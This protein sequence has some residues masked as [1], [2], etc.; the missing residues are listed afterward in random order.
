MTL[1]LSEL[2]VR[3][4]WL[5]LLL[6]ILLAMYAAS[7]G[8]FLEFTTDYR[9]FFSDDNPQLQ[10]FEKLQ[11]TYTKNDNVLFVV[12][13]KDGN[14]F[15]KK[16]LIAVEKLT[17]S[18]WQIPHSLRV[19]SI[20]NFQH[21]YAEGDDLVVEDLFL[22]VVDFDERQIA[23]GRAVALNEPLL[24]NRLISPDAAVTGVNATI[25][26]PGKNEGN[27]VVEVVN[28]V[29]ALVKDLQRDNPEIDVYLTGMT[30][31]N[32]AF[33]ESSQDDMSTLVPAMFAIVIIVLGF[34]LRS[35][36]GTIATVVV[37]FL[38][39]LTAMGLTGWLGIK[40][41]PPSSSAPTIILTMAVAH[42]VHILVNFIHAMRAGANKQTAMVESLRINI[43]PIFLTSVTTAIGF[44]SMNFS[45]APPFR[46]LGN[47]VAMGVGAAFVL[48]IT[49][50]PALMMILPVRIKPSTSKSGL[51]MD[52][53]GE[54]VVRSRGRLLWVMAL[55][56]IVLVSFVPKNELNDNFVNYFDKSVD[57]RSATDFTTENLTG[58]YLIEYSLPAGEPNGISRPE[59]LQDVERFA[60][61]FRLQKETIHVNS[62]TDVMKRL[63]RNMHNDDDS[64]YRVPGQR[65]LAAQY[66]LLYE[67]SLPFGLDLNNQ[68]NVD[69]SATRFT[70]TLETM[71]SNELIEVEQ[72]ASQWLK[73]NTPS[74]AVEGSSPSVMFAHIGA[75]NI[76]SM[77]TGTV[78]ALILISGILI[79]ALRSFKIGLISMIPNLV[80]A[81]MAFGLWGLLNGQVG[82]GLSVVIGMT[83]G[84]V[85][86]DT[87]HFL[88]KYLRARREKGL[89]S[90]ASVRYAFSTVGTAL[91]VT[92]LVLFFGFLVLSTSVFK[93]NSDMGLMTA[94][95]I[96]LAL[97]ADFLFLPPLLMKMEGKNK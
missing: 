33:S 68:I 85:V 32:N 9:V 81:G 54:F 83:L 8:R 44:M 31:M 28:Y 82:L 53:F 57:F 52:R 61:W 10:A 86:D 49:V 41:T 4:R 43:Q 20:T 69:K 24:R 78:L 75:R 25:Q 22:D 40:L 18:A 59:Y 76:R 55:F 1:R 39:I 84:I 26:L 46:D 3:L 48:S 17:Q 79:F 7:G 72:R 47:I 27:E 12:A 23:R 65:D 95:T 62:I 67:M 88:S 93:L 80:P 66:L 91:W 90:Q 92:S 58:I 36:T 30:M 34:M 87:V 35:V 89:D 13:P 51:L 11:N 15:T 2:I 19:D 21:T 37:I 42:S 74:M 63:N 64:Y 96:A 70:V 50:L 94:I 6:P 60:E 5:M 97:I 56:V 73:Q 71:T 38:S 77:L 29:R 45:D 16:T 14:V